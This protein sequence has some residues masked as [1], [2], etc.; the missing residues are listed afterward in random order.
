METGSTMAKAKAKGVGREG[1]RRKPPALQMRGEPEW[2]KWLEELAAY[3]RS[4]AADVVDRALA[5]YA[6]TIG[7][8]PPPGR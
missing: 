4:S 1:W 2:K 6:R 7:F 5:H 3:D 8:R